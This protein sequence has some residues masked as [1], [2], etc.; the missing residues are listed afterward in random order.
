VTS[1]DDYGVA[2][3]NRPEEVPVLGSVQR[4]TNDLRRPNRQEG[5]KRRGPPPG[6][7]GRPGAAKAGATGLKPKPPLADDSHVDY[8]A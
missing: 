3:P 4:E 8:Y 2:R 7:A 6:S 1:A 5:R